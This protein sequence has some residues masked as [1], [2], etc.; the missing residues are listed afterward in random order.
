MYLV[1]SFNFI[2][3]DM[4]YKFANCFTKSTMYY[5]M[6]INTSIKRQVW[7]KCQTCFINYFLILLFLVGLTGIVPIN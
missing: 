3:H 6:H 1:L 2:N 4:L 5:F 7:L